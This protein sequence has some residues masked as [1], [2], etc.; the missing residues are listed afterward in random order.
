MRKT[1]YATLGMVVW[2][3]GKRYLRLRVRGAQSLVTR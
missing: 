1:L 2:R 3:V